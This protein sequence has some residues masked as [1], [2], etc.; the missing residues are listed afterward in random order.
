MK[1]LFKRAFGRFSVRQVIPALIV[2]GLFTALCVFH[3]EAGSSD[4]LFAKTC[5]SMGVA[6]AG[7]FCAIFVNAD[8]AGN[9]CMRSSA[10][11]HRLYTFD[12]PVFFG[13]ISIGGTMLVNCAYT[14]FIIATGRDLSNLADMLICTCISVAMV[15]II[16]V[17][18]GLIR[19]GTIIA[20]YCWGPLAMM[21]FIFPQTIREYG[22]GLSLAA[23]VV[24]YL[25][26]C[27]ASV[28]AAMIIAKVM[29]KK[30]DFKPFA[31]SNLSVIK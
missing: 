6:F 28:A 12:L 17:F 4:Y 30:L 10:I 23:A 3:E 14:I 25:V 11:A 19:Y 26:C 18:C 7:L 13:I 1:F 15:V 5:T 29:Y 31:D 21:P 2:V 27:A 22:F 8:I 20:I 9:R 16:S 24:I